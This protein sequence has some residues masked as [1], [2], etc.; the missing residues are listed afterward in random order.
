MAASQQTKT[1]I[2][3]Y[4]EIDEFKTK[5]LYQD[6]DAAFA[7]QYSTIEKEKII[8]QYNL[9]KQFILSVGT[10][11][12]R[13]NQLT[14]LKA[15]AKLSIDW[16]LVL[17]VKKTDYAKELFDFATKNNLHNKNNFLNLQNK[18]L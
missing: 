10:I 11:E 7:K 17:I 4:F 16:S 2:E 13:K 15:L 18:V 5:V 14:I 6:C 8:A 1:D 12:K 9:P 3:T